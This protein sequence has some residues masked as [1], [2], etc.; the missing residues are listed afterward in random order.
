MKLKHG[1]FTELAQH[2]HHRPGYSEI[3]LK[4]LLHLS[5]HPDGKLDVVDV[6]AGTGKLTRQLCELGIKSLKAIEP[7]PAMRA[8]GQEY[9][10]EFS[11][12][13]LEG[14]GEATNLP[15][16]S[17]DWVLMGSSFH[18][19]N[20]ERGLS[21]FH[22]ILRPGGMLTIL[23]NPRDLSSS[24]LQLKIDSKIKEIVPEIKRVSSGSAKTTREWD[25]ELIS[26]GQFRD[27]LFME[28]KHCEIMSQERYLGAWHSVNDIQVQA[29]SER[30]QMILDTIK[31]ETNGLS[32]VVV[33][34]LTR[35]WT[36]WRVG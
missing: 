7:N 14:S 25:K 27:V 3:V 16:A 26:T 29:G 34:Y 36:A 12:Q 4:A 35:A 13:W 9:T 32:E 5:K 20:L 11:L 18:W 30:W 28:S 17:V 23:W 2:Y 33:P 31:K 22:R 24:E 19:V 6:G 10:K 15:S 21:E 1:D 8:N